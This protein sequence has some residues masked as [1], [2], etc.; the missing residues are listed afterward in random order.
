MKREGKT[1]M[2]EIRV[3][4]VDDYEIVRQGLRHVLEPEEDMVVV[5]DCTGAEEAF[6]KVDELC[7]DVIL[8]DDRMPQ[9]DGIEATRQLKRQDFNCDA[10]V[11]IFAE[12]ADGLVSAMEAGASGYLL[13]DVTHQ[14]LAEAI[15]QV[16]ESEHAPA[17]GKGLIEEVELIIPL[18]V[19]GA[20][21]LKFAGELEQ[22]LHATIMQTVGSWEWGA[23]VTISVKPTSFE[24]MLEKLES[25]PCVERVEDKT[26]ATTGGPGFLRRFRAL[27][28]SRNKASK[29]IMLTLRQA[30]V[31]RQ[32][33]APALN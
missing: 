26:L 10:G 8:M 6:Y 19:D 15:R 27:Q 13:K 25:I 22:T 20:Q 12:R 2:R 23:A 11:I 33:L 4:L 1:V 17:E 21:L 7:P 29:S 9:I 14:E 3:L 18:P 16:Y 31:A 5:G 28:R 32:E 30:E 24:N